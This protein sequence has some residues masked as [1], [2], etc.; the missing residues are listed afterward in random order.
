MEPSIEQINQWRTDSKNWK[1][2]VFYYNK[3][4]SRLLVDKSN[5]NMGST[6]NFAHP[7]SYFFFI[8]MIIFFGIVIFTIV[9]AEK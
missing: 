1:W 3:E 8:G 2:R 6:I 5:P 9:L 4:D 7:K